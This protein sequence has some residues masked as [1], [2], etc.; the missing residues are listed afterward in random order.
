M[1]RR[2]D[3]EITV[4]VQW[5]AGA[6]V[7][8]RDA[9]SIVIDD[10]VEGTVRLTALVGG[11]ELTRHAQVDV[12]SADATDGQTVSI[13]LRWES[14]EHT[15]RFPTV[16]GALILGA[17]SEHPSLST[18]SIDAEHV[19]PLGVLGTI[20]DAAGGLDLARR[21]CLALLERMSDRLVAAV[22]ADAAAATDVA[23]FS[24]L[25]PAPR[26]IDLD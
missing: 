6:A 22:A 2:I 17:R 23:S 14:T 13:P 5:E 25:G 16:T 26:R 11:T 10:Q 7:L 20:G 12:G 19:P 21:A 15:R 18:L 4:P 1:E 8:R 24:N 3:A 9:A